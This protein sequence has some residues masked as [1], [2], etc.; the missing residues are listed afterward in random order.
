M[1]RRRGFKWLHWAAA[2][3]NA[4]VGVA[5]GLLSRAKHIHEEEGLASLLKHCSLFL[6]HRFFRHG[7]Y[8][9][10]ADAVAGSAA[11]NGADYLPR[12]DSFEF[13]IVSSNQQADELES[14]GLEFR[15][16]V[17]HA[18]RSLDRGAV[19]FCSFAGGRLA[20][21]GWAAMTERARDSLNEPPFKVDF[22]GKE[23]CTGAVWTSPE[24]RRVG[25]FLYGMIERHRFLRDRGCVA[26]VYAVAKRNVAAQV[27]HDGSA[28]TP[29]A[30][31]RYLKVLWWKSWKESLLRPGS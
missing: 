1:A 25:L 13:H 4:R 10:Y 20:S 14:R 12:I 17:L 26:N 31:G 28:P 27:A 6:A 29:Y 18:R 19:A 30:E 9:L 5:M 23:A 2:C 11:L 8:W 22:S 15:S 21:I 16:R 7:S 24:Y 3:Y